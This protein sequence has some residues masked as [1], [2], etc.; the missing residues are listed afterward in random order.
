MAKPKPLFIF[1]LHAIIDKTRT[2]SIRS[3]N[4]IEQYNPVE[5]TD[6]STPLNKT[7]NNHGRGSP[8]V[9]SKMFEPIELEIAMSPKPFLAT[10][11]DVIKSGT[12]VPAARSVRP[13]MVESIFQVSPN[14]VTHQTIN[15]ENTAIQRILIMNVKMNIPFRFCMVSYLTSGMVKVIMKFNGKHN[16]F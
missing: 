6:L 8:I 15:Q 12:L 1:H 13:I 11:T 2:T 4:P 16:R 10:I 3:S 14:R 7:N 9:T 5:E